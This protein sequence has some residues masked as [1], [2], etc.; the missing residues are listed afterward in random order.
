[1]MMTAMYARDGIHPVI[2][3]E[4]LAVGEETAQSQADKVMARE[5]EDPFSGG[6]METAGR[7]AKRLAAVFSISRFIWLERARGTAV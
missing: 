5:E 1:M 3:E 4:K 2:F 6:L 7:L